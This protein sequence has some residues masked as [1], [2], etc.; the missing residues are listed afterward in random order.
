M[1]AT[2]AAAPSAGGQRTLITLAVLLGSTMQAM[3]TFVVSVALPTVQGAMSASHDEISWVLTTYLIAIAVATPLVGFIA[4]RF[5]RRRVF[6]AVIVGFVASSILVAQA[7]SLA[8]IV[9]F[10]GLQG[11]FGAGLVP[12]SQ[13][14]LFDTYPPERHGAAMGYFTMGMMFGLV[15]GPPLGGYITEFHSW[16]W[17]FLINV[18]IGMFAFAMIYAFVP[19]SERDRGRRFDLFGYGMLALGLGALQFILDRGNRADW[20]DSDQI[21]IAAALA[22][23]A[24]YVF[25]VHI[26]TAPH[27]F[28]DPKLFQ[29]RN[30]AIGLVFIFCLGFMIYGFVGLMPPL[31]QHHMDFPVLTT[32][33]AMAPRGIGTFI[34]SAVAGWLL[35]RIAPRPMLLAAIAFMAYS[36]WRMTFFTPETDID[37]IMLA[38]ILQGIGFGTF[39]VA[40]TTAAFATLPAALR[41]DGTGFF[42]TAR[43]L[44][45]SVGVSVLVTH[46]INSTQTH[47]AELSQNVNPFNERFQGALPWGWSLDARAGLAAIEHAVHRHAEFLAYLDDFRMM[48]WLALALVPLALAIRTRAPGR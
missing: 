47:H 2:E 14:V 8:E 31:L 32:G 6:L 42:A 39:S 46:L 34:A 26:K 48:T 5:G 41:A 38:V 40:V 18:P 30:Y 11:T 9:A 7:H 12:L 45:S 20:F 10:R 22:V 36:T 1:A 3:D 23:M 13:Q 27:P 21:R 29:D 37:E 4:R 19:E 25:I 17:V 35:A 43:R 24:L 16:R 15:C 44:G 28:V 33:M